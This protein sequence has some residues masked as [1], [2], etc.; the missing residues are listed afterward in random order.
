VGR[1]DGQQAGDGR[2][3]G[4]EK[5]VDHAVRKYEDKLWRDAWQHF[6]LKPVYNL[7]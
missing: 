7:G 1:D 5:R 6:P 2:L 3:R 4:K